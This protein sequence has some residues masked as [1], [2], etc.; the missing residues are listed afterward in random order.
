MNDNEAEIT[1]NP[2]DV[3][4]LFLANAGVIHA[5]RWIEY[6]R[7]RGYR[8]R[9]LTL[10]D[11]PAG[12]EA[13]QLYSSLPHR[14][15][16]IMALAP[17]VRKLVEHYQ[18][19]LINALFIPDYGWLGAL[20]GCEP[21]VVSA[22]GSD[23]L[24][25]PQKSWLHRRRI[26]WTLHRA[27][28]VFGDA[29][30]IARRMVELG[31]DTGRIVI[32][33]LGVDKALVNAPLKPAPKHAPVTVI[34]NRQFEP[35]YRNETLVNAAVEL[36][37]SDSHRL[38]FIF[39]GD[40]S[41]RAQVQSLAREAGV[42][43]RVEFLPRLPANELYAQLQ[44]ADI[45]VSCAESDGTSVS[46]LEAMAVGLYP[47]VTDIPANREWIVGGE[48]GRLFPVGDSV[49]LAQVLRE[50]SNSTETWTAVQERNRQIIRERALWLDNMASVERTMTQVVTLSRDGTARQ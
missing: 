45:F 23:V 27:A 40:G 35:V 24:I 20:S 25:S 16:K 9:W 10:D 32:V 2:P 4:I 26:A 49:A 21:L 28:L 44:Q 41:Q 18:P 6:F 22:W 8:T 43:T 47:V 12:I 50:V 1:I 34:T 14:A 17:R 46:L 7:H 3:R 13:E 36:R 33:P 42:V 48:N 29:K 19:H 37:K 30:I 31:V 39:I 5:Q 15:A 11:V 38:R